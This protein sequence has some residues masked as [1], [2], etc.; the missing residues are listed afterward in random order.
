[1]KA[2]IITVVTVILLVM[3]SAASATEK[4][5]LA[6]LLY[7]R[8]QEVKVSSE[9][10]TDNVEFY[11]NF[12]YKKDSE[13][14]FWIKEPRNI[15]DIFSESAAL[16]R[17]VLIGYVF[18]EMG[19]YTAANITDSKIKGKDNLLYVQCFKDADCQ[20]VFSG[21]FATQIIST[22]AIFQSCDRNTTTAGWLTFNI[23]NS[24]GYVYFSEKNRMSGD[25]ESFK[26][27]GGNAK[28][29][30]AILLSHAFY[31]AYRLYTDKNKPLFN[32]IVDPGMGML[33]ISKDFH[34]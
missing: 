6:A 30:E 8:D 28:A 26:N 19:H 15:E 10:W 24:I 12:T 23:L 11:Q 20:L 21:G 3:T 9:K 34:F 18:H 25:I 33:I 31:S 2:L 29:L 4:L 27:A 13:S 1:M 7:G 32:M 14:K 17:G 5:I 16:A 22:E